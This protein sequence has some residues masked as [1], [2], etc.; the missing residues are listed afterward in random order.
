MQ[1]FC[2][3]HAALCG[4]IRNV[5]TIDL[6]GKVALVSG[7]SRGI[8]LAIAQGLAAAGATGATSA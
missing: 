5:L 7:G 4:W 6:A 2:I 3:P 1:P 8:G